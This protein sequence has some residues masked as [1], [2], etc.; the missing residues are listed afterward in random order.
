MR[1][2]VIMNSIQSDIYCL[3]LPQPN[4]LVI[5]TISNQQKLDFTKMAYY[6]DTIDWKTHRDDKFVKTV[7]EEKKVNTGRRSRSQ[8]RCA[9]R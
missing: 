2:V 6:G 8:S 4:F 7:I 9:A 1:Y 5:H 3:N